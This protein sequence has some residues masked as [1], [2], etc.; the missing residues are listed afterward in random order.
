MRISFSTGTFYHRPL[1]YSL[2]LARAV[3]FDGVELAL[4]VEYL[5][6]GIAPLR[7]TIAASGVPVLSIHP[8]FLP[9]PGWPRSA[10]RAVPRAVAAALTIGAETCVIHTRFL[11]G[12]QSPRAQAYTA[13]LRAGVATGVGKVAV[14]VESN[15]YRRYATKRNRRR[16]LLDDLATLVAFAQARDCAI[17]LDTCHAGANGEDLLACYEIVR[18][19]LRNIHLSDAAWRNGEVV[20]HGMPGEG[21]LALAPFLAALARDGY[22]GL[23]TLE[24]APREVGWWNTAQAE[25]RL[26][27]ALAY[28]R[29]AVA[30]GAPATPTAAT[31]APQ[32]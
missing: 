14:A 32:G 17:T 13:A 9:F 21:E 22:D 23:V 5:V 24:L 28:V 2:Q 8:P 4:G 7:E 10:Q 15:Q 29:Q 3:G 12:E 27:Q 31:T 19:A 11:T 20:T 1:A 25:R 18:P 16:Y 26:G 6:R 30:Q